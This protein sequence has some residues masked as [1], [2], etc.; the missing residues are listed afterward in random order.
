MLIHCPFC[1]ERDAA[2]FQFRITLGDVAGTAAERLYLRRAD[3][4]RSIEHW[5]HLAGCQMWLELTRDLTSGAV[6]EVRA[7]LTRGAGWQ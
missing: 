4:R 1:G 6:L 2:E 5:Q 7:G 3:P